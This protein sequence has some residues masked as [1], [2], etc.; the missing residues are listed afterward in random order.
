MNEQRDPSRR[1]MIFPISTVIFAVLFIFLYIISNLPAISEWISGAI[2]LI[3][4]I[5]IGALIAYLCNPVL[6]FMERMLKKLGLNKDRH[7]YVRRMLG[8]ILTYAFVILL[9]AIF[10]LL[11]VPQLITSIKELTS[12]YKNLIAN[13]VTYVNQLIKSIIGDLHG[14]ETELLNSEAIIATVETMISKTGV[15]GEKILSY[16][17]SYGSQVVSSVTDLIMALFI[18]FYLLSSKEK[19]VAQI[20]K[21]STAFLSE[22][23]NAFLQ[24]SA[25]LL[26]ETFGK[27]FTGVILDALFIGVLG[28]VVFTI[29]GIPNAVM[30][31]FVVAVTNIIPFFGPFLGAIPSAFI[32]FIVDPPKVLPFIIAILIMQQIDGN[33]IAPKILGQSTGVSSLCVITALAIMGGIW[34]VFGM[35]VGV[36]LFAVIIISIKRAAEKRLTEKGLP[37]ELHYYSLS[38][39][40]DKP[41]K[42]GKPLLPQQAISALRVKIAAQVQYRRAVRNYKRHGKAQGLPA[43]QKEDFFVKPAQ[44]NAVSN[45]VANEANETMDASAV[46]DHTDAQKGL[47]DGAV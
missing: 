32:I 12:N 34:G 36:P 31:S 30:I 26:N 28:F 24:E 6:R 29:L 46:Q 10:G 45:T 23:T 18:S 21:V 15:F 7:D 3:M 27:Y 2:D 25:T 33:I 41:Q 39:E 20:R 43:P 22:K 4:P 1:K 9:I 17:T 35:I 8:I 42:S 40:D 5:L 19:R 38:D 13:A 47:D 16:I 11:I 44:E 37:I 14:D